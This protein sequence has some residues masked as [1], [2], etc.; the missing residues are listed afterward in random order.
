MT[1]SNAHCVCD[2]GG[3]CAD[4]SISI[5]FFQLSREFTQRQMTSTD[6]A[7]MFFQ[8]TSLITLTE[9]DL[10]CGSLILGRLM[11]ASRTSSMGTVRVGKQRRQRGLHGK[12][13]CSAIFTRSD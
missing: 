4:Y 6:F 3:T 11:S 9:L 8:I 1:V 12:C 7:C 2:D 5:Y 13:Q 10:L